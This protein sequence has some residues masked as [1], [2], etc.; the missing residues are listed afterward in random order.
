MA[1]FKQLERVFLFFSLSFFSSL[2]LAEQKQPEIEG[3]A[4][5]I[6]A[7]DKLVLVNEI[8]T[9]KSWLPAGNVKQGEK[10]DL[11]AQRETWEET[12]LVVSINKVLGQRNNTIYYDCISDSEILAFHI[13]DSFD[14][15]QIP[16][17]FAPHYGVEISSAMLIPPEM[18]NA[19]EYRFPEQLKR[20]AG[21]FEQAT[22]Q[23]VRYVDNLVESAPTLHQMELAWLNEI[24]LLLDKLPI[25]AEAIVEEL[26]KLSLQ[27]NHPLMLLLLFP[28]LYWR[29]GRDFSYKVFFAVTITSLV[30]L[31]A[32]QGFQLPPPQV[33]LA[34]SVLPQFSGY[35]LPSLPFAIWMCVITLLINK[36]RE[37]RPDYLVGVGVSLITW[38]AIS[39]F[40]TG[41]HFI[42]DMVSG[43]LIGGLCAWH[44]IRLDNKPDVEVMPLIQSKATW[45][46]LIAAGLV[47]VFVWPIPVFGVWL[48]IMITALGVIYTTDEREKKIT[49]ELLVPITLSMVAVFW[50]FEYSEILVSRSSVLSFGL[51]VVRYP[52]LMALFVVGVR[53]FAKA[54]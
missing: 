19:H 38:L 53:K 3:A 2:L 26:F 4:C 43:L 37:N 45:L 21:Y 34:S 15:H 54:A 30:V 8:L 33:Y 16:I 14:A 32:K 28:Y 22:P 35:S 46:G 13:D 12:G 36:M 52:A 31:L 9:G 50:L 27:L 47:M 51:D 18:I 49:S 5:V 10:P 40:Y 41:T 17:W 24:R 11:A 48:G 1:I 39:S 20:I 23:S 25:R 29:F 7:D 6:R 44:L 42:V